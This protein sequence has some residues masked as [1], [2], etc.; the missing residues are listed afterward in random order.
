MIETIKNDVRLL[1]LLTFLTS[2]IITLLIIPRIIGLVN[3]KEL[4][5]NPNDRSV[6]KAKTPTLGGVAF[7]VS[8][9]IGLFL[10]QKFDIAYSSIGVIAGLTLLFI[11]GLKDDL[12]VLSAK[13][14]FFG[15][16][17]AIT[18]ILL[19]PEFQHL[20]FHG[21]FD[22]GF[23]N[24]WTSVLVGYF[25]IISIV[26]GYNLIDGIDGL[27]S[28]V[29][30]VVFA[31]F[32][33]LFY[34]TNSHYFFLLSVI[35]I[36]FLV[37]FLRFNLSND[38]KIFM[39]DTGSMIVGF[40]MGVLMLRL[41]NLEDANLQLL[42]LDPKNILP[43]S[44]AILVV[45]FLDVIRV[46]TIRLMNNRKPFSPDRNHI[47]HVLLGLGWSHI[48]TSLIISAVNLL[49]IVVIYV[50][51]FYVSHLWLTFILIT[52]ITGFILLLFKL[53]TNSSAIKKK[54]KIKTVL[55]NKI[56]LL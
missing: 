25:V 43:L 46:F 9:I 40:L 37:A 30:I 51:N 2:F 1:A 42:N 16:I 6:H 12:M 22:I 18:F 32:S 24:F 23:L 34:R 10:I 15:Q 11:L 14:K 17:V 49:L 35:G 52:I 26:N 28:M 5:D 27:A 54:E 19:N 41:L 7:F 39:G 44:V 45:P 4:M 8:I 55:K 48:K 13:T 47:H 53:N 29:G 36:G 56:K 50:L 38:K 21:F 33:F 20:G 31:V 3:Y